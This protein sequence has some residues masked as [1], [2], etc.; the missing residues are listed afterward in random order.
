MQATEGGT[1]NRATEL[2]EI[3]RG[4][5]QMAKE[6]KVPVM[7]LSQLNRSLEQRPNKRPVMSDLRECVTG[8]TRV[9]LADGRRVA[10]RELVGTTPEVWAVDAEQRLMRARSDLVW[11]KG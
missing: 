7:A 3:S 2:S 9:V 8:D 11:E 1:E 4:L 5:K 6:L 10:V